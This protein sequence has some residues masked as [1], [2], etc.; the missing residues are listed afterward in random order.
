VSEG[1]SNLLGATLV[2][3]LEIENPIGSFKGRGIDWFLQNWDSG[4]RVVTASAGNFGQAVAYCAAKIGLIVDVFSSVNA[5]TTK[6]EA[7]EAF[8]ANVHLVG[9]DF[10]AAKIEAIEFA[11]KNGFRFIEDGREPEISE[12]A[13]T[14]GLELGQYPEDLHIIYIPVGN[15]ALISGIGAWCKKTMP[16]TKIVGVCA[17][18]APSMYLSWQQG[19]SIETESVHTIADGIAC[20]VPV[21]ESLTPVAAVVDEFV[22]VT[23][24]QI[25]TAMRAYSQYENLVVEPAGAVSLAASMASPSL[26][27]DWVVA[28]IVTGKNIDVSRFRTLVDG[29]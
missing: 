8:G 17:D 12:G 14:I 6:I 20:R 21:S 3:K 1:L 27:S 18:A 4:D 24:E 15:G 5:E 28:T 25:V 22:L 2:N 10:D 11:N 19:R 13:G 29:A 9:D 16:E 23:E 7:M 26:N